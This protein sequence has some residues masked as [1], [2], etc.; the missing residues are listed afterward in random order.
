M[1]P[2]APLD[3]SLRNRRRHRHATPYAALSATL[4][5]DA[6]TAASGTPLPALWHWLYFLPLHRQSEIGPDGHAQARRLPAAG[7]AAAAHVG[8]QPVRVPSPL[9]VGDA[10][11]RTSTIQTSPKNPAAQGRWCSSRCGTRSAAATKRRCT[12]R[13]PRHRLSRSTEPGR[14]GAAAQRAP[15]DEVWRRL[16]AGRCAALPLLG[17]DVQRPPH[18]L[19]PPLRDRSRRLS[20]THR[21]RPADRH[22][23][24]RPSAPAAA[25]RRVA[26]VRVQGDATVVRHPPVQVCGDAAARRQDRSTCGPATTK[27]G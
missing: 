6:R 20:G 13:V 21:A 11:T 1:R 8:R 24:A 5:R 16:G 12:H 17:A 7:A 22:A 19:R 23:A 3:R 18:P 27:A 15:T 10:L 9:R 25:G 2:P 26:H 4:D 14:R